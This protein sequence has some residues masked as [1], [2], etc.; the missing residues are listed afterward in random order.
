M[1]AAATRLLALLGVL[2]ALPLHAGIAVWPQAQDPDGAGLK[3][4]DA[5]DRARCTSSSVVGARCLPVAEFR[6]DAGE[7]PS[8]RD[9]NWALGT[10]GLQTG[11]DVLVFADDHT[12]RD[13]LAALVHLA[14]VRQTWLWPG[15]SKDLSERMGSS[16]GTGRALIRVSYFDAPMRDEDLLLKNQFAEFR[17]QGWRLWDG[18]DSVTDSSRWLIAGP[19]PIGVLAAYTALRVAPERPDLRILLDPIA[20]P[21]D[22]SVTSPWMLGGLALVLASVGLMA[23]L[24]RRGT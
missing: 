18:E 22:T 8:F 14:G 16:A 1:R 2:A 24:R 6:S 20:T 21:E 11:D 12:K 15:D 4:L 3:I 23:Y 17:T 7:L 9:I 19:E 5:R 10:A 13:A